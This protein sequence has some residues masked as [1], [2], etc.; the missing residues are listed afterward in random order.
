VNCLLCEGKQLS[1]WHK[2]N[3]R[4]YHHCHR[5]DLIFVPREQLL[6]PLDEKLRYDTHENDDQDPRYRIYLKKISDA[7]LSLLSKGAKGLD[8]GCG[9]STLLADI[10]KAEGHDVDSYDLYYHPDKEIW[11]RSYDFIVMSEVIEHIGPLLSEMKRVRGLLNEHGRLFIKT[12]LHPGRDAFAN[13]YYK[14]DP[15]HVQ[16]FGPISL[17]H[18]ARTLDMQGP[19]DLVCQDLYQLWS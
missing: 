3:G 1:L 5:C 17:G 6:S 12:K 14:N 10:Y 8:F 11:H 13:W 16:F 7:T 15:T 4:S 2:E 19:E 18:L 9:A